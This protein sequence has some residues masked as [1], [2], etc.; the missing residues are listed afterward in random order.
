MITCLLGAAAYANTKKQNYRILRVR[1]TGIVYHDPLAV[2]R[3]SR[4]RYTERVYTCKIDEKLGAGEANCNSQHRKETEGEK[5]KEK[6]QKR[7][8]KCQFATR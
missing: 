5:G 1:V 8:N 3:K 4:N 6:K 2:R 7:Q